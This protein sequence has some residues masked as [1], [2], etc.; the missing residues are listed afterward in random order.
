[1]WYTIKCAGDPHV[2]L[3]TDEGEAVRLREPGPGHAGVRVRV[4]SDKLTLA[5]EEQASGR[6]IASCRVVSW[7]WVLCGTDVVCFTAAAVCCV[8]VVV[9][10][11]V[12]RPV[13]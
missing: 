3:L 11:V 4:V 7:C 8:V 13:F 12:M 1:M 5:R 10:C 9:G 2:P 6:R